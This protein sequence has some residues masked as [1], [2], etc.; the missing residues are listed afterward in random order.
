MV[1]SRLLFSYP[2]VALL[3]CL[4]SFCDCNSLIVINLNKV[5]TETNSQM[6]NFLRKHLLKV[7]QA[8]SIVPGID[9]TLKHCLW[10]Q[11]GCVRGETENYSQ[12]HI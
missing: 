12:N 6:S 11:D 4:R 8:V 2:L 7:S 3:R 10:I 9:N 1:E 5:F